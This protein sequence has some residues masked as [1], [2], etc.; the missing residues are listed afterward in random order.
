MNQSNKNIIWVVVDCV[1]NYQSGTDDRD[2][3]DSMYDLENE[4][5]SFNKMMVSAPSSIMS[6]LSFLTGIPAY[7]LAGNF[8][9]FQFDKESYWSVTDIL[10]HNGYLNYSILNSLDLR[11]ML[12]DMID[13][14]DNK[15]LTKEVRPTMLRWPNSEVTKIFNNLLDSK[16]K[17]PSFHFLW[18]NTRLDPNM[19][20]ELEGLIENIKSRGLY[21][22]SI[23]IITADHGYPDRKR[24]LVS[25]GWDLL[26]AGIPHD[27]LL[28]NDNINVPFLI[29]YPGMPVKN[30]DTLVSAEDIVPTLLDILNIDLP[31][32]KKLP[33]FGKSLIPL[34]DQ[35]SNEFFHN[36]IIRSDAR[37]SLQANRMTS[38]QKQKYHYIVRHQDNDEQLYDT[39]VDPEE[40]SN[41]AQES[42]YNEILNEFRDYFEKENKKILKLQKSNTYEK[43]LENFSKISQS[44]SS[45]KSC[46]VI[47]FSQSYLYQTT[48]DAIKSKFPNIK[49]TLIISSANDNEDNKIPAIEGVDFVFYKN[50]FSDKRS[51]HFDKK[52]ILIEVVDDPSSPEFRA[53]YSSFK[54]LT[55]KKILRIDWAGNIEEIKSRLFDS[56]AFLQYKTIL[57]KI[58]LRIKLGIHE[59][60]YFIDEVKRVSKRILK[61]FKA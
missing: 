48:I 32:E 39:S 16:P 7:Y 53:M 55:G 1:R 20:N 56:P 24:G 40:V 47:S 36:R 34:I 59:P 31:S 12:T 23:I 61:K 44:T 45:I 60:Q 42:I 46:Y 52:D 30:I 50:D 27:V 38:L 35:G 17:D 28:T 14:I 21:E 9:Q 8:S 2:K 54:V 3:L 15:F 57:H 41:I 22:D 25:D 49:I 51:S 58:N 18:Y 29:K 19:S 10:K 26:K 4:F 13:P 33:I 11:T 37:F 6:A 5:T 43:L